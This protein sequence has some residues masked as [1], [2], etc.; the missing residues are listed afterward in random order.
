MVQTTTIEAMKAMEPE[1]FAKLS[2]ADRLAYALSASPGYPKIDQS[3]NWIANQLEEI[4]SYLWAP[5]AAKGLNSDDP[6]VRAKLA[7]TSRY[8]TQTATGELTP[9][10][11]A[12]M[13]YNVDNGGE[14]V[15]SNDVWTYT[16][17]G[18]MQTGT[19]QFG[20]EI[21][22]QNITYTV[23]KTGESEPG[24]EKTTQAI[25]LDVQLTDGKHKGEVVRFYFMGYT[26]NGKASPIPG[27]NY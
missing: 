12:D 26:I 9:S 13:Q 18:E 11:I 22:W 3:N 7:A 1:D 2:P 20:N 5:A 27:Y 14:G 23:T 16:G 19:D 17:M 25:K 6:D 24:P 21:E 4:P 15:S 8:Y 10:A